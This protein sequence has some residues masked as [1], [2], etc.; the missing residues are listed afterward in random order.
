MALI[1]CPECGKEISDK[2]AACPNCGAPI[3]QQS[4]A[5]DVEVQST[6][7]LSE[8]YRKTG[9][10]QK[11]QICKH[12]KSEI[13]KGAKIC[14]YC[15][16]KQSGV[17]KWIIIALIVLILIGAVVGGNSESEKPH[18]VVSDNTETQTVQTESVPSSQVEKETEKEV[19]NK[20][21]FSIGEIAEYK[22]VQ[23][24]VTG[25]EEST[26]NDWGAPEEGMVFVFPEIEIVNNSGEEV[27]ISSMLSFECYVD[28]YKTDFSS[29]A[30]MAIS[31]DSAKQQLDGSIAPGKKLKG[32]LGIEAPQDWTT[33]EIYY[34]DNVWLGSNFSFKISK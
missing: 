24:T 6:P 7:N 12:C 10:K 4:E 13:P 14:P 18:Q 9:E 27:S 33:I 5:P 25:Y 11:T 28:D 21:E 19:E 34:K 17:L 30:F 3:T 20:N 22:D 8:R 26:G 23:I 2:A 16:K 29:S 32:V 15:K 1:K 31:T